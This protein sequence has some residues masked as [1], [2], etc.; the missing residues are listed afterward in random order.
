[1]VDEYDIQIEIDAETGEVI[2]N[3]SGA[4]YVYT[5]EE[6]EGKGLIDNALKG[7]AQITV[8][9]QGEYFTLEEYLELTRQDEV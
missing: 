6:L 7:D 9:S 3:K 4:V 2:W 5:V 8:Y 1:M